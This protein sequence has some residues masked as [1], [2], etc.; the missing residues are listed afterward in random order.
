MKKVLGL[1]SALLLMVT[2]V[3]FTSGASNAAMVKQKPFADRLEVAIQKY[4]NNARKRNNLQT[5]RTSKCLDKY[6][7]SWARKLARENKFEHRNLSTIINGCDLGYV[8]ENIV[9]YPVGGSADQVG[10]KSV[11]LWLNSEGHRR[12]MLDKPSRLI[13]LGAARTSDGYWIVVQNFAR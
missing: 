12:N 6:A 11:G 8:S 2:L 7:E 10:K 5:V 3:G 13:G 4:T 1:F 9:K